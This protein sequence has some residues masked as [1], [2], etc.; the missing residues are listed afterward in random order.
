MVHGFTNEFVFFFGALLNE[1]LEQTS[2]VLL[3]RMLVREV[4]IEGI[5]G[6]C[7]LLQG[8]IFTL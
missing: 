4:K 6:S 3:P 5:G 2:S 7:Q 1:L 8:C